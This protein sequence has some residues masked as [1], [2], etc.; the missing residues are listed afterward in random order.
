MQIFFNFFE[1]FRVIFRIFS[2]FIVRR[3]RTHSAAGA[4]GSAA[5]AKNSAAGEFFENKPN[6]FFD[7]SKLE[8]PKKND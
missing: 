6:F 4:S 7:F 2:S 5:G 8:Q 1:I 3:R